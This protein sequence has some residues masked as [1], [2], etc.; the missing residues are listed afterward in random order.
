MD[1]NSKSIDFSDYQFL[2]LLSSV[3]VLK[4]QQ[5]ILV[6]HELEKQLYEYYKMSEFKILFQDICGKEDYI[7]KENSFV[8]LNSAFQ[9]AYAWGLMDPLQDAGGLKSIIQL[10]SEEAL[11][12][13]C[14]YDDEYIVLM[15]RMISQLFN[16]RLK[17]E[18]NTRRV[19]IGSGET[20]MFITK[21]VGELVMI[22]EGENSCFITVGGP[23]KSVD[24]RLDEILYSDSKNDKEKQGKSRILS[25]FKK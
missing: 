5:Q 8:D 25:L 7:N 21:N 9:T 10:T 23:E 4:R 22:G 3:I 14:E 13:A 20:A 19:M 24:E 1:K 12:T 2:R 11:S 17:S 15:N 16:L 18:K 6:N